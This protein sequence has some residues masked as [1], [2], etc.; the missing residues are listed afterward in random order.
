MQEIIE[1]VVFGLIA[2]LVGTG[3]LWVLGWLFGI[4]GIVF[5]FVAGFIWSL[6]R[7]IVP[8]VIIGGVA[9]ALIR[10]FQSQSN[11]SATVE[12]VPAPPA[13][14]PAAPPPPAPAE[15]ASDD[16][17]GSGDGDDGGSDGGG[18]DA[19]EGDDPDKS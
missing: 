3:L 6:L 18:D 4:I 2:L 12:S 9:Y 17:N 13:P 10:F 19:S 7:F 14:A 15:A 11:R 8:I 1:L 16:G 5:N